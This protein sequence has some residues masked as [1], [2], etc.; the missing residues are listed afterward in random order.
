MISSSF[1][2]Q[3][4]LP[5]KYGPRRGLRT[6]MG[7]VNAALIDQINTYRASLEAMSWQ[8]SGWP[9]PEIVFLVLV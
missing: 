1:H 8:F 2:R 6:P 4:A 3:K 7:V 5:G 9:Q